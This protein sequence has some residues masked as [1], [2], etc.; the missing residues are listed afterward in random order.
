MF[1]VGDRV[2]IVGATFDHHRSYIGKQATIVRGYGNHNGSPLMGYGIDVDG[3]APPMF[4]EYW[5]ALPEHLAPLI[6]PDELAWIAFR[7]LHLKPDPA[8]ILAKEAA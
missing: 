5:V 2:R 6:N 3:F 8:L 7:D 1:K 4:F